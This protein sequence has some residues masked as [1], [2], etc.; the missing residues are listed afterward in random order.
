MPALSRRELLRSA[1]LVVAGS[2]VAACAGR[3]ASGGP[4]QGAGGGVPARGGVL[5]AAFAGAG[6]S[7]SL[8]PY[9]GSTP[10]EF[11]RSR[12]VYD[13][14]FRMQDGAPAGRLAVSAEPTADGSSFV[15]HL[16]E[17]VTWQDG[18][19]FGAADVAHTLRYLTSPQRPYPSELSAFL[20]TA[21]IEV[22]DAHT[23][24]VPTLRP[25]GD[26]PVLF[27]GASVSVLKDGTSGFEAGQV[28]GTGPYRLV[29]FEAGREARLA[30][31][32]GHWDG[33]PYADE[34]V[35]L[36]LD[37]PQARVNAV[38]AGQADFANDIPFALARTGAGAPDLE[39]RSAG[40]AQRTGYGFVLN[41]TR[42]P[43]SDP[44]VRRAIRLAVDRQA[45]V[46]RVFLGYGAAAND[47]YGRGVRYF[48]GDVAAPAH[49][50]ALARTLLGEAGATGAPLAIR[51]AEFE[52]GLNASAELM[53]ESLRAVGLDARA[54]LVSPAELWT[55][56][57]LA[58]ADLLAFPLGPFPLSVVYARSAAYPSLAFAD[59]QLQQA[60]TTALATT[61]DAERSVAWRTAQEVMADRGN[62]VVWGLGDVLSLARASVTGIAV[63]D[64][65]KYPYLGKAGLA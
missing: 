34:L 16:R 30:R 17:G 21:A 29:A 20:D 14:L 31:F 6:P 54:E 40:D 38:R 44:R 36:S 11:V 61:D 26:P 41:T 24:R 45:M 56:D 46:D 51:S 39:I 5:R 3:P 22:L 47:L 28:V 35:V 8:N 9:A 50:V 12:A 13:E 37:D 63:H 42:I 55:P 48:A 49:D 64:S 52:T 7:E 62:W 1:G 25:V 19:P 32:D 2:I 10:A 23:V 43:V 4:V 58:A 60:I 57:S 53:A 27:A 59:P 65:A 18:S 15:L 33:A